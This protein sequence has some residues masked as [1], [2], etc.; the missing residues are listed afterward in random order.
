MTRPLRVLLFVLAAATVMLAFGYLAPVHIPFQLDFQVLWHA[1][2]G[3]LRGVPLYDREA[4][5]ALVAAMNGTPV[6]QQFVIPFPYPPWLV[7]FTLPL[8]LLPVEVAARV[9]FLLNVTM[10]CTAV[11]L[12]SRAWPSWARWVA[13]PAAALLPPVLGALYVGQ[14]VFPAL[15][16]MALLIHALR[17]RHVLAFAIAAALTSVKPHVGVF[18]LAA[19]ALYLL[20][21]EKTFRMSVLRALLVTAVALLA[22]GF[23]ADPAWPLT[24]PRSLA[25]FSN[26]SRCDL[27]VSLPMAIGHVL[28]ADF[29]H[30]ALLAGGL[31]LLAV[32]LAASF[33]DRLAQL[34]IEATVGLAVCLG[35]LINPYL[36]NYDFT[37]LVLAFLVIAGSLRSI[38]H[39]L[40]FVAA[41]VAPWIGLGIFGRDGN[42]VLLICA[43]LLGLLT[44]ALTHWPPRNRMLSTE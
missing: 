2:V 37:F 42:A 35:L 44:I 11:W 13:L 19:A 7:T 26:V 20:R 28:E 18:A 34:D 1:G 4:Q 10:L 40:V 39:W 24:Y 32:V 30:A 31:M 33:R 41:Y 16:G 36:Q 38:G 12:L 9:W 22:L 3:V 15:L 43:A 27:C 23:I 6:E 25:A 17:G 5:T 21:A 29:G 8:A 14:F